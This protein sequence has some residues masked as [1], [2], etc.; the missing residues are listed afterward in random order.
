[1]YWN[2]KEDEQRYPMSDRYPF[3]RADM[4]YSSNEYKNSLP[5]DP[6]DSKKRIFQNHLK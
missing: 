2:S 6:N 1:M 5:T 4:N 3:M